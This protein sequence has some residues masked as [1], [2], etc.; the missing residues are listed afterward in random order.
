M[1]ER[2]GSAA[3]DAVWSAVHDVVRGRFP[4]HYVVSAAAAPD[5]FEIY[6]P[7]SR[8]RWALGSVELAVARQFDGV[9]TYHSISMTLHRSGLQRISPVGLRAFENR[10]IALGILEDDRRRISRARVWSHRLLAFERIDFGSFNP[11]RVLDAVLRRASWLHHRSWVLLLSAV[12][13]GLVTALGTR[14]GEFIHAVPVALSGWGLLGLYGACAV[15]SIPHEGGHAL[16]CRAYGVAVREVGI[17]LRSLLVFAWTE[18]DRDTWSRL[19]RRQQLVTIAAGSLGSISFAAIGAAVWLLPAPEPLRTMGVLIVL[20]GT[21]G[22]VPTLL[23]IFNGDAYL[24]L[25][26][27]LRWPNL[28][29]RSFQYLQSAL[30]GGGQSPQLTIRT[31]IFFVFFALATVLGRSATIVFM[32]WLFWV[33]S[34]RPLFG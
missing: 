5:R 10:L 28:R 13:V 17:G 22:I 29:S 2:E 33:C 12:S 19:S 23:P 32:L 34:L 31:K 21:V 24:V 8:I 25:T 16:S 7:V 30:P 11:D 27:I 6:D 9:R 18:S 1:C 3:P 26:D 4:A 20:A 14:L 15:S